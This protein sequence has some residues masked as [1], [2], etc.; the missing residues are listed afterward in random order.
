M[1]KPQIVIIQSTPKC[2]MN[3]NYCY[4]SE[5]SRNPSANRIA[6]GGMSSDIQEKIKEVMINSH[7]DDITINFHAGEPLMLPIDYYKKAIDILGDNNNYVIQTNATLIN[8][9]WVDFF[10]DYNIGIGV[11]IDGPKNIHDAHRVTWNNK[12]THAMTERGMDLMMANEFSFGTITVLSETVLQYPK[13]VI[14]YLATKTNS[15]SFNICE[16]VGTN[17]NKTQNYDSLV[18]NFYKI[19]FDFWAQLKLAGQN[20]QIREIDHMFQLILNDESSTIYRHQENKPLELITIDI[21]GNINLFTPETAGGDV[22]EICNIMDI[23]TF[24]ELQYHPKFLKI[25]KQIWGGIKKCINE[26]EYFSL[27]GG[28]APGNKLSEN[29]TV[30]SS[31][32][33]YCEIAIKKLVHVIQSGASK[34]KILMH[35]KD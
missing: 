6:G 32:T 1:L 25:Y 34:S 21:N 12:G 20:I 27:C 11:S 15:M 9:S 2:N 19:L 10:I 28:G 24:D 33:Q 26:C 5:E 30:C 35:I 16:S 14:S 4:L 13:E 31:S 29:A 18:E 7:C 23:N 8:Q 22:F 3:C 17:Q